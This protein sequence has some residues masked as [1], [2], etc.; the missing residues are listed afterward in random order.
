MT[1]L[2]PEREAGTFRLDRAVWPVVEAMSVCLCSTLS[3]D[4]LGDDLCF[5]GIFPGSQAYDQMGDGT[6]GQAWVRVVRVFPSNTFPQIEQSPRRS[7]GADLAVELEI[8]VLRCAP[9][10]TDSGR[11]PP[12]MSAQW[13]ATRL[14]MADMASMQRAV[15]CCYRDSD[16]VMLGNYTPT[17][18]QGG[19]VGGTWQVLVS[20]ANT[21]APGWGVSRG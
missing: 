20:A 19:I 3:D 12:S 5:C 7:C 10:P 9:M 8:G 16:L 6:A 18:P 17:G 11:V 4:G 15:Q 2:T 21:P 1:I 14:Q 13:D